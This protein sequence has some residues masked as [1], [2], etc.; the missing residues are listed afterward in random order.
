MVPGRQDAAAYADGTDHVAGSGVTPFLPG[1]SL[2]FAAGA[3]LVGANLLDVITRPVVFEAMR[4]AGFFN[5]A[6]A[7]G[8]MAAARLLYRRLDLRSV[9]ADDGPLLL[10]AGAAA[11][12]TAAIWTALPI[13]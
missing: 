3:L 10:T 11:V 13:T 8:A 6:N 12:M 4:L 5:V 7:L 1:D 9:I 2:L